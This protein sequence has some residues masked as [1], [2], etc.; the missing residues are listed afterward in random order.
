M[1]KEYY[2]AVNGRQEGPF[3]IEDLRYKKLTGDSLVWRV[4]LPNCRN[5]KALS[6]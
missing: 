4:G 6:L 1:Q 3:S 2:L 5:S